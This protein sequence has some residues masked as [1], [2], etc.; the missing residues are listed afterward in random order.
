[1]IIVYRVLM[2]FE[3][4]DCG[5]ATTAYSYVFLL[6]NLLFSINPLSFEAP[7]CFVLF[8]ITVSASNYQLCS[9]D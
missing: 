7:F 3:S 1:M 2:S 9:I 8:A 5:V 4:D 6:Y